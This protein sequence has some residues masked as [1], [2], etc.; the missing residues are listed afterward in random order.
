MF[1]PGVGES[2]T[3]FV[4]FK[5]MP[6]LEHHQWKDVNA[7]L[8]QFSDGDEFDD[9]A[10]KTAGAMHCKATLHVAA[11]EPKQIQLNRANGINV[12]GWGNIQLSISALLDK[13]NVAQFED[14][15]QYESYSNHAHEMGLLQDEIAALNTS[16]QNTQQSTFT[17]LMNELAKQPY[18]SQ[19][20]LNL[21]L[22]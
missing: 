2:D 20:E 18:Q 16:L 7:P 4:E 11:G 10:R 13:I 9:K 8:C 3:G 17:H 1:I 21:R 19:T 12:K 22:G 15:S 5:I 14:F 6:Q